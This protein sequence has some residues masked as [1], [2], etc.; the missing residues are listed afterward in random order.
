MRANTI[1]R[2]HARPRPSE[3]VGAWLALLVALQVAGTSAVL[4]QEPGPVTCGVCHGNR[5]FLVGKAPTPA[6]E[7]SLFVPDSFIRDTRHGGLTCAQC[8]P[9]YD[10][11]YPH[12][13]SAVAVPCSSCHAEAG[14][15]W[16]ASVHAT[17]VAERGDAPSCVGCHGSHVVLGADD[18]RSPTHPLNVASL[19]G[20]CHADPAIIGTYF[21]A[22]EKAQARTAVEQFYQTVHG[23]ALTRA[24][25]VVSATCNDCHRAHQ[26]LP[27]ESPGSSVSRDSI[28]TTCGACHEGILEEFMSSSHG[29]ALRTGATTSAGES[30]PVCIECHTAHDIVRA[31]QPRWFLG[32]VEECG[33]CH[34]DLYETYFETYHGKATGL[35]YELAA[36]CADCHTAH[37]MLPATDPGSSVYPTNR[38]ET[39][40]VCH[41]SANQ[42]FVEYYAHGDP[43]DRAKYPRLF[44]P[45]LFMTSL[46]GGVFLFFGTH[47]MLWLGRL[48][49][50]RVRGRG[51]NESDGSPLHAGEGE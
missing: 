40:A 47:T 2:V 5:E 31:D 7:A 49:I 33:S 48:A 39:C 23:S 6:G 44:W 14:E 13:T 32:V 1:P 41:P 15:E 26:V 9:G 30:A 35:G 42:N 51:A 43:R 27:S 28:A 37:A 36:Q 11:G 19:C 45:W 20:S 22:P 21:M 16:E 12:R 38:V 8:H 3:T 34:E 25:L 46:L 17:N 24:G 29:L 4:A 10:A 50:D 18:R